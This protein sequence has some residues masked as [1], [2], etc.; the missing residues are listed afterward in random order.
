M[1]IDVQCTLYTKLSMLCT[2]QYN[3]LNVIVNFIRWGA[4]VHLVIQAFWY[5][6]KHL[7]SLIKRLL[8]S[9]VILFHIHLKKVQFSESCVI[10]FFHMTKLNSFF[11]TDFYNDESIHIWIPITFWKF[12]VLEQQI[13]FFSININVDLNTSQYSTW[14]VWCNVRNFP[15]FMQSIQIRLISNKKTSMNE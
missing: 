9:L 2:I 7:A 11:Y 5:L 12:D 3:T 6:C 8:W 14:N 13:I 10:N 1:E 4:H 15:V